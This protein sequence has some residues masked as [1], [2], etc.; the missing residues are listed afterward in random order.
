[1][2][3]GDHT[4]FFQRHQPLADHIVQLRQERL[5]FFLGIDKL[6]HH[7]QVLGAQAVEAVEVRPGDWTF[8][9]RRVF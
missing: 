8:I 4:D 2:P 6:D 9:S 3:V 1:M 7:G 5:D